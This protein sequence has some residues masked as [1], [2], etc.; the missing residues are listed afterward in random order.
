MRFTACEYLALVHTLAD[1]GHG[2]DFQFNSSQLLA[3]L[4]MVSNYNRYRS[5]NN[6]IMAPSG[7]KLHWV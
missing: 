5:V 6:K 3:S 2:P 1:A 4:P 7:S